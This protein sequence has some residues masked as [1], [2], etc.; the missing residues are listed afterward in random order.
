[1]DSRKAFNDFQEYRK[2]LDEALYRD[3]SLKIDFYYELNK[4]F[5]SEDLDE[6]KKSVD[7]MI[8]TLRE[9]NKSL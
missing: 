6:L 8:K 5:V 1:M 9:I 2:H 7:N 4:D 3:K